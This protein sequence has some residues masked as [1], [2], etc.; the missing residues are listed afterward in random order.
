MSARVSTVPAG[1]F[2]VGADAAAI[3]DRDI[4]A[5]GLA[6]G[7]GEQVADRRLL[8]AH[9]GAAA[10]ERRLGVVPISTFSSASSLSW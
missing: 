10:V 7:I 8:A 2:A 4:G 6:H 9:G 3:G 5:D 1:I